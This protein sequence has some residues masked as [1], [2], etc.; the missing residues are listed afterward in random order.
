MSTNDAADHY[1]TGFE[2]SQ[3]PLV[4]IARE[5]GGTVT[6]LRDRANAFFTG[7]DGGDETGDSENRAPARR[8]PPEPKSNVEGRSRS[9]AGRRLVESL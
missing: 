6:G 4:S 9:G 2:H 7:R 3:D 5:L 1:R 8:S